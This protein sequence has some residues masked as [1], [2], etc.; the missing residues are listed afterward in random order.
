M[1]LWT[2]R[3]KLNNLINKFNPDSVQNSFI[4]LLNYILLIGR[5]SIPNISILQRWTESQHY[6]LKLPITI[7]Q[8]NIY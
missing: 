8:M 7:K 1:N 2:E 4:L 5:D 3:H 6:N